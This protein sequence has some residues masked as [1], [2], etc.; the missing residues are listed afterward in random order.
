MQ[1]TTEVQ[2]RNTEIEYSVSLSRG[3]QNDATVKA[4][5]VGRCVIDWKAE[6][7]TP[8]RGTLNEPISANK[9]G[10]E[11]QTRQQMSE[12]FLTPICRDQQRIVT[13][14]L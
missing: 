8:Q 6:V 14:S 12:S 13:C 10:L 11:L 2:L 1:N 3:R 7:I 9:V 5:Y 4:G